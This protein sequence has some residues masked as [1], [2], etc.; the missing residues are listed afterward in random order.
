MSTSASTIVLSV[1]ELVAFIT[2]I[3]ILFSHLGHGG[4]NPGAPFIP[5]AAGH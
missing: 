5:E 3:V 4:F 2:M 1:F